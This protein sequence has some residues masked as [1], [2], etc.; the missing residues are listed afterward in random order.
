MSIGGSRSEFWHL[1]PKDI[2]L[3]FKAHEN[4][5][6]EQIQ[7]AWIN[8]FYTKLALQSSV[9]VCGLADKKVVKEMPKYPDMPN[10]KE[11]EP[12]TQ[13]EIDVQTQ[14]FIAK[15]EYW[16]KSNNERFKNKK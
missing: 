5:I 15:M 16:T 4:K 14:Y 8:G 11:D 13:A 1:T 7:L 3:D 6:N 9:L 12:L 2:M 10:Q